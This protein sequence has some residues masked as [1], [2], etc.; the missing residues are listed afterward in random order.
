MELIGRT[1]SQDSLCLL[2]AGNANDVDLQQLVAQFGRIDLIDL[3]D[4]ALQRAVDTLP[5]EVRPSVDCLGG[6]D[7]TGIFDSIAAWSSEVTEEAIGQAI[8]RAAAAP[9]PVSKAYDVVCSACLL[10]Q[11]VDSVVMAL[12]THHPGFAELAMTVRNRHLQQLLELTR[13]GGRGILVVDFVSS[14]TAPQITEVDSSA[15]NALARHC[16]ANRNFFTGCNPLAIQAY[17]QSETLAQHVGVSSPWRWNIGG[18][19]F[20]VCA[21]T[22][23]RGG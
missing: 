13:V 23:D 4:A 1:G 8:L 11:L 22:F 12:P 5:A 20:L 16:L 21:I 17:L 3:D 6:V 19:Q 9:P 18:K 15:L 14:L 7:L 2:G 10:S